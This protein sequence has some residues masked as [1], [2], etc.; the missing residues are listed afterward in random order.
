MQTGPGLKVDTPTFAFPVT[1]TGR[2]RTRRAADLD[3]PLR[4][5]LL[6]GCLRWQ[7]RVRFDR[8]IAMRI[9]LTLRDG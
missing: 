1:V 7:M 5:S 3:R 9:A 6:R 8:R 4:L 2:I